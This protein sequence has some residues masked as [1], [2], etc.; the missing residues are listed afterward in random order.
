MLF[1]SLVFSEHT[2]PESALDHPLERFIP[3]GP[4]V[5]MTFRISFSYI[6]SSDVRLVLLV[7]RGNLLAVG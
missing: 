7:G 4:S 6:G 2:L 3:N 5:N 1:M